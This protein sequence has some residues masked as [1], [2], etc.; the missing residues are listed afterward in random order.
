[1]AKRLGF[2]TVAAV[3]LFAQTPSGGEVPRL[4]AQTLVRLDI[5]GEVWRDQYPIDW[6][7]EVRLETD[8]AST[9]AV[10]GTLGGE[11]EFSGIANMRE[12]PET[13]VFLVVEE[14]GYV[15]IRHQLTSRQTGVGMEFEE[16]IV[17]L[18]LA[19]LP[20]EE[21]GEVETGDD[22]RGLPVLDLRQF[23]AEVPEEAT[24][25]YEAALEAIGDGDPEAGLTYLE[26]AVERAPEYLDALSRLGAEYL[27]VGRDREA[28]TMLLRA[29]E[30]NARNPVV[31][32][33]LGSM[34]FN[35]A[36]RDGDDVTRYTL[37][38]QA[39]EVL[40][41]AIRLD[42]SARPTFYLGAALYRLG[43]EDRAESL[44]LSAVVMDSSLLQARLLLLNLY[45]RT[46]RDEAA[47]NQIDRYLDGAPDSD[48]TE[49]LKALR[50]ELEARLESAQES[51]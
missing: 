6:S 13:D 47:L 23:T 21:G 38:R 44:L 11:F 18:T 42:L 16:Q 19:P 37:Y 24:R 17:F 36:E 2:L 26:D 15:P 27:R 34:Y 48:M 4:V 1:M 33:N 31:L 10:T 5:R 41:Q 30:L 8:G 43:D 12:G 9:L 3:I 35:E 28:A 25:S 49:Q 46:G 14:P 7:V 22:G 40:E 45:M 39:V 50:S 32:T 51:R 29:L 20:R